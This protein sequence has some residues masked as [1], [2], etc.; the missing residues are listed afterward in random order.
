MSESDRM[1][2]AAHLHVLLRRKTGRVTDTEWMASNAEYASEIVR[3]ARAHAVT[4][5]A[6]E[7]AQW[8]DRLEQALRDAAGAPQRRPLLETARTPGLAAAPVAAPQY[9]GGI[10]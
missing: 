10:R 2:V 3:F 1:A 4:D 6:S 8:A 9:V 5:D 7:L